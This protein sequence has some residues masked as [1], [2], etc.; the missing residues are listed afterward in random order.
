MPKAVIFF[1]QNCTLTH[2]SAVS[3]SQ[4]SSC[5]VNLLCTEWWSSMS[6]PDSKEV[7]PEDNQK[8][9]LNRFKTV[10][11]GTKTMMILEEP[12]HFEPYR[13]LGL[14]YEWSV[15]CNW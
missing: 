8:L 1:S 13:Y 7:V 6:F 3:D 4:I 12:Q 9:V 5:E 11:I 15:S 14:L 10:V 2:V